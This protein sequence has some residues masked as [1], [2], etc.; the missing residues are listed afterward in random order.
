MQ[1]QNVLPEPRITP[2]ERLDLG[3]CERC[4]EPADHII[5]QYPFP[6]ICLCDWHYQER[7]ENIC[8]GC[9]LEKKNL[10]TIDDDRQLCPECLQEERRERLLDF[11]FYVETVN[12]VFEKRIQEALRAD[13]TAQ[14]KARQ[15]GVREELRHSFQIGYLRQCLLSIA[16]DMRIVQ[17]RLNEMAKKANALI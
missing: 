15:C 4:G 3:Y 8:T 9:G 13:E 5:S 12:R 11:A 6:E 7:Q 2:V 17:K 14:E 1:V 16:D 10:T